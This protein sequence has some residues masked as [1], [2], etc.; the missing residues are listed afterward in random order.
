MPTES[1]SIRPAASSLTLS[2]TGWTKDS[3]MTTYSQNAPS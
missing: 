3:G 1:G 2:G